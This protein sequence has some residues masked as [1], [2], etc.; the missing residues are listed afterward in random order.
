MTRSPLPISKTPASRSLSEIRN[1]L[2]HLLHHAGG[3]CPFQIGCNFENRP[4]KRACSRTPPCILKAS[5]SRAPQNEGSVRIALSLRPDLCAVGIVR[6]GTF[7]PAF[8][9]AFAPAF[10][11]TLLRI[12]SRSA[13]AAPATSDLGRFRADRDAGVAVL[14]PRFRH[15]PRSAAHRRLVARAAILTPGLIGRLVRAL[16]PAWH[17]CIRCP[18]SGEN[19]ENTV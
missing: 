8:A 19:C 3:S 10:V 12:V 18:D 5:V 13:A 11:A 17:C 15:A 9:T 16:R 4:V 6:F 14:V 1:A 2:T 7:A